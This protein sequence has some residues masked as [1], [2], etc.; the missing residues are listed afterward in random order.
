MMIIVVIVVILV[1]QCTLQLE[2]WHLRLLH[3]RGIPYGTIPDLFF[4]VD[5]AVHVPAD[6]E[7]ISWED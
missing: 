3:A 2:S 5:E 6:G 4:N 1:A 7:R